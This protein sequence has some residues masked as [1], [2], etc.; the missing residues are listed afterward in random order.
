MYVLSPLPNSF[1]EKQ[2]VGP[3]H[4]H[5]GGGGVTQGGNA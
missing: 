5:G 3:V 1:G 4:T 2:V